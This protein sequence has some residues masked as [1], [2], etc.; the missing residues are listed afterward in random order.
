ML[1]D[2]IVVMDSLEFLKSL[3]DNSV[4]LIVTSPPY[5]KGWW[6]KNRNVNNG[7][8]TKSRHIDYGVFDDRMTPEQYENWQRSILT[9][10]IRVIKKT[11]SIFYNHIDILHEHLTLFP[12]Y[13]LDY[14]L[15]Q[16]IVW[17]K[18][19]TPRI[20]KSYF[21]PITEYIFW[22]KKSDDARTK[23]HRKD[24]KYLKSVWEF[25]AA[26]DNNHPAPFPIELAENCILA[27]TDKEDVVCDPFM[28]SGTTALAAKL[29]NRHYIGSDLNQTFV[30]LAKI[31][32]RQ[33]MDVSILSLL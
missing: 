16:I 26:T 1:I 28:G 7:P 11:G 9:E 31:R 33:P 12:K 4:D 10:C 30:S 13:V 22:I 29:N 15:K 18:R 24:C 5:N 17:N 2:N 20:D 27:C 23:F 25:G 14:P 32:I 8:Y 6:S 19:N 21:F 3:E